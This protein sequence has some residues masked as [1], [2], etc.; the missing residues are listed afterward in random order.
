[1]LMAACI[2]PEPIVV[3]VTA[4]PTPEERA[5]DRL[6]RSVASPTPSPDAVAPTPLPTST[7]A[8]TD[9]PLSVARLVL[10]AESTVVGYWSDGT[11]D[12]EVTATLR[13][14]GALRLDRAQDVTANCVAEDDERRDCRGELSLSLPDGFAPASESFTLRL[15]MG[16]TTLQFDY[17]E[18][19][20]LTLEVN[21]PERIL[22]V[23]RDLWECYADRPEGGVEIDGEIFA[24]CGGWETPTVQ[25][26]LNDVAV[27]VWGN[28]TP[29][30]HRS[31]RNNSD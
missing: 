4:T 9:T 31:P 22:G 17:G 20:P 19:Q 15:P 10:D 7:P 12:V 6:A 16:A 21:V 13:N 27:K 2:Q 5:D 1:M 24:G 28:R 23:D 8:S 30:L 25:K 14:E 18:D 29:G 11:V 26:W 3:V